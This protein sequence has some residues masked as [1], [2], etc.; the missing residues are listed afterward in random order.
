MAPLKQDAALRRRSSA[1]LL[2]QNSVDVRRR[3]KEYMRHSELA[4]VL[5]RLK[6]N[7]DPCHV[8]IR[9]KKWGDWSFVGGHVEPDEKNDWARAAVRDSCR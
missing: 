3:P 2:K 1:A 5:I 9:H 4:L 7:A 6:V 8:L